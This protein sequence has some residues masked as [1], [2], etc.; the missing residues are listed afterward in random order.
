MWGERLPPH[1]QCNSFITEEGG[2]EPAGK[3]GDSAWPGQSIPWQ[4]RGGVRGWQG[5]GLRRK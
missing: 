3:P 1:S 5:K 4:G 2:L